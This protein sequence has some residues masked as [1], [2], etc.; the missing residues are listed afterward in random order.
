MSSASSSRHEPLLAEAQRA[1][2]YH[3][4]QPSPEVV[5]STHHRRRSEE[6]DEGDDEGGV[7]TD[8]GGFQTDENRRHSRNNSPELGSLSSGMVP[9]VTAGGYNSAPTGQLS[10]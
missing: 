9:S 3:D 2:K 10:R 6:D 8:D 7:Q 4:E 1:H 5:D